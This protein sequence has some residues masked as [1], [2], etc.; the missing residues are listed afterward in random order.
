MENGDRIRQKTRVGVDR[1]E[2][3]G[4]LCTDPGLLVQLSEGCSG[5]TFARFAGSARELLLRSEGGRTPVQPEEKSSV[6]LRNAHCAWS[7][8]LTGDE[9]MLVPI[10]GRI[11]YRYPIQADLRRSLR[12]VD[13]P[14][15]AD[16]GEW[17]T[18]VTHGGMVRVD[19]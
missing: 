19:G 6:V 16:T 18:A 17:A 8:A 12:C 1:S 7:A 10:A 3:L 2:A 14:R 13:V 4:D 15:I 5:R 9:G 11:D